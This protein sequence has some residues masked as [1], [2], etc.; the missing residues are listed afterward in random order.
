MVHNQRYCY[1][2][3]VDVKSGRRWPETT[4]LE[5]HL[6]T[7]LS[8]RGESLLTLAITITDMLTMTLHC[9]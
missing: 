7:S 6:K 4:R 1:Q 8:E 9:G 3:T 5:I 2:P